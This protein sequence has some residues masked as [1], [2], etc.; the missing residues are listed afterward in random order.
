M[1]RRDGRGPL[2]SI[3]LLAPEADADVQW[4]VRELMA[5][6]RTQQDILFELN[7]RLA[8]IGFGPVSPAS[9][10]RFSVRRHAMTRRLAEVREISAAVADS[11]GPEKAD[12]VT[13]T[14]VQLIKQAALEILENGAIDPKGLME[15]SRALNAAVAA[16][17]TSGKVKRRDK[18]DI[19]K[20]KEKAAQTAADG[21]AKAAPQLD[22]QKILATI[23]EAYGIGSEG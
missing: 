21:I 3:D 23:R 15:V 14:L 13:V 12:N 16:Q 1:A 10:N 20:D 18:D 17:Q 22:P 5:R 11:L 19:D 8:V 7:D 2:S 4:A 6:K 9:F